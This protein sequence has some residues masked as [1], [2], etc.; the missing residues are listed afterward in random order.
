[1]YLWKCSL[2][3]QRYHLLSKYDQYNLLS[4]LCFIMVCL[5]VGGF[6]KEDYDKLLENCYY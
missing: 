3:L 2:F 4:M 6:Q 5:N 1:M